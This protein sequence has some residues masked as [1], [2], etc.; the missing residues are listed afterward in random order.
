MEVALIDRTDP[1]IFH[2]WVFSVVSKQC[3]DGNAPA[4]ALK[5]ANK[6]GSRKNET[7]FPPSIILIPGLPITHP[8]MSMAAY[9]AIALSFD[10][11]IDKI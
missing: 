5:M 9:R 7:L 6:D 11:P 4:S 2:L 1:G 3:I 10:T 8:T